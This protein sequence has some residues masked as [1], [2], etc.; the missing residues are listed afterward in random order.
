MALELFA[1]QGYEKTSLREI[2]ER[3]GVT[4]AALYYHF[5]S[6]DDIVDS[7]VTDWVE[8][9]DELIDWA[10]QQPADA[11][12]RRAV[13]R[14]YSE[15]FFGERSQAV[16]QFV[17]QN[18]TVL[19]QL[20]TGPGMRDRMLRMAQILSRPDS[21]PRGLLRAATSLFAVHTS[22]FAL[23]DPEITSADGSG[24]GQSGTGQ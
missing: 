3:L 21:S 8:R 15:E 11:A 20:K 23:R 9:L 4:K 12:G 22:S 18:K 5:K 13:L 16:L 14:R 6:K 19:R 1:E 10:E 2:A 24:T 17:E 7:V